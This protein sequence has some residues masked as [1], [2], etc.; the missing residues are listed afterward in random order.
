MSHISVYRRWR[1]QTFADVIGQQRITH[2]LQ[3]AI[4]AGRITHA[5]LFAGHRGTGKTTVARILAKALNCAQ[6][7]TPEP[8]NTCPACLAVNQGSS[9]DVI[10][11]DGASHTQVDHVRD[12]KE[13]IILAPAASRYKVYIID[14]VHM[15]SS[16]AFNALLKTLEEPPPHAVFVLVTTEPH[17]IPATVASRCQRF[18]FRRVP[19]AEI[20][21]RLRRIAAAE[22]FAIDDRA[23]RHIARL[24]DGSVRDAESI[25]DQVSAYKDEGI[26]T[27]DILTILGAPAE[28]ALF[29]LTDAL[30]RRDAVEV[31]RIAS[32]LID[33][34]KESRQ[35]MRT[36]LEH[37]RDLL[38]AKAAADS[39]GVLDTTPE[40]LAALQK[41]AGS[42]ALPDLLRAVKILSDADVEARNHSQPRLLLEISLIR[43]ARPEMDPTIESLQARVEALEGGG[44]AAPV[45]ASAQAP[46]PARAPAPAP[47]RPQPAPPSPQPAAPPRSTPKR[48]AASDPPQDGRDRPA[49][50]AAADSGETLELTL[51]DVR[52]RWARVLEEVRR[53]RMLCHA[54]LIEGMP[55][56]VRGATLVVGLRPGYNFHV[57]S[58]HR[59]ENRTVVEGAL[60][61]VFGRP[62]TLRCRLQEEAAAAVPSRE[63]PAVE[64][65]PG[66]PLVTRAM[67]L[68][69][70][71]VVDVRRLTD[72]A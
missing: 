34:G 56:E 59:P 43:L 61:R 15:L 29:A 54:L 32:G 51:Q 57:D 46:A 66:D 69:G 10:E 52:N 47:R 28:E 37:F 31:L 33:D 40:R 50:K 19:L 55:L 70:G 49:P 17:R 21:A 4:R 24:A 23:L 65:E 38:I 60:E 45:P 67:E 27:D 8:D 63:G 53:T 3:N 1:P 58:L 35:I 7:P 14:E 72:T 11:I 62:M 18:D 68:F 6:G 41:Q 30:L 9:L 39:A 44:T 2:T 26:T 16:S 25:L 42:T 20:E 71:Q 13:K 48:G 64:P 36:L 5:Y 12:L 22:G